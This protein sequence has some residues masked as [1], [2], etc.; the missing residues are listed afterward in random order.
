[1]HN[2]YDCTVIRNPLSALKCIFFRHSL[3]DTRAD[4]VPGDDHGVLTASISALN[5]I[6]FVTNGCG[7]DVGHDDGTRTPPTPSS[8]SMN[9]LIE[10]Y[11]LGDG[12]ETPMWQ[13]FTS[14]IAHDGLWED[15]VTGTGIL[16]T[17]AIPGIDL[18]PIVDGSDD[19]QAASC[20]VGTESAHASTHE[21]LARPR[22][23]SMTITFNRYSVPSKTCYYELEG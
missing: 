6:D 15:E 22:R 3:Q 12:A 17:P 18:N 2:I 8:Q 5:E 16:S 9:N 1:L 23:R 19:L 11:L 10:D 20:L 4:T 14:P 7:E 13:C 21:Y